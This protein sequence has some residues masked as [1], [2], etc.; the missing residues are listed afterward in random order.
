LIEHHKKNE[1]NSFYLYFFQKKKL[2]GKESTGTKG[3]EAGDVQN[4]WFKFYQKW[5]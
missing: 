2:I 1:K 5:L 3:E 4:Y